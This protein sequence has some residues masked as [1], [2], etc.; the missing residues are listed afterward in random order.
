MLWLR[1]IRSPA[2]RGGCDDLPGSL[3]PQEAAEKPCEVHET[4]SEQ[5]GVMASLKMPLAAW[6][7]RCAML[8]DTHLISG[9][10]GVR[11]KLGVIA[12]AGGNLVL[13]SQP[14][15]CHSLSALFVF[16]HPLPNRQEVTLKQ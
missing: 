3:L 9:F 4:A 15:G 6:L 5:L 11:G 1:A 2:V 16:C 10:A 14:A 7:V 8:S 13:P 12:W